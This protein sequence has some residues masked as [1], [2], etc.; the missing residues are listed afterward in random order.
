[1]IVVVSNTSKTKKLSKTLKKSHKTSKTKDNP[2]TMS[3][4][5]KTI[6]QNHSLIQTFRAQINT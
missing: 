1:M 3:F 5:I 2:K 4:F 6:F